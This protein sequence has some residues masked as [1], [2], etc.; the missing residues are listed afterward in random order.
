MF[1]GTVF[2]INITS[3]PGGQMEHVQQIPAIPG[4]GLEGDRY[5]GETGVGHKR[6]GTGR[7]ITLI[8]LESIHALELEEG[9]KLDPGDSRRNI[10]TQGVPLNHLVDKEFFVGDVKLRGVRLCEPCEHLASL[11]ER[12]VL[13]ALVHRGGLRAE[14]L[15]QGII[16]VGD[17]IVL[18]PGL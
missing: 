12:K 11:T 15:T 17:E 14:I 3:N 10:V 6:P 18:L 9:I 5:F 2:S 16:K 1:K 8:E 13:P 7:D 4:M